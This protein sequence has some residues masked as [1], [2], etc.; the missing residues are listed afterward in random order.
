[1]LDI[2]V[3]AN[4]CYLNTSGYFIDEEKT[5]L[6]LLCLQREVGLVE[7]TE[8]CPVSSH[9]DGL[10]GAYEVAVN[11][12]KVRVQWEILFLKPRALHVA[13][14]TPYFLPSALHGINFVHFF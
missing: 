13:D 9:A 11:R 1:M 2:T 3:H 10:H 5:E 14:I 8:S 7:T 6:Q 4:V 12:I